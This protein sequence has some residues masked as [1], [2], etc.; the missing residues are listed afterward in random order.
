MDQTTRPPLSFGE[1]AQMRVREHER[2]YPVAPNLVAPAGTFAYPSGT[3][4][5]QRGTFA[6]QE[7]GREGPS[8]YG[9][10]LLKEPVWKPVVPLYFWIGGAAGAASTLSAMARLVGGRALDPLARRARLVGAVGDLIG[11][12]LLTYDLGRPA[13]FLNMLRVFNP[14]SPMSIGSWVL[15]SSG[16]ANTGALLL[17]DRRGFLGALG[18]LAGAI[19]G[20]IGMPLAGYTG[21]L[22]ANTAVP[23]WNLGRRSLPLLFMASGVAT[24]GSLLTVTA[25]SDRE[26]AAAER[27]A[28]AGKIGELAAT[29]AL[30]YDVRRESPRAARPL[31]RGTSGALLTTATAL[32]AASLLSSLVPGRSRSKLRNTALLGALGSLLLRFA[33]H[34]AGKSSARDPQASFAS[35]RRIPK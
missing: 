34:H 14:R 24:A 31:T 17:Q 26:R 9:L 4:A 3:S 15:A 11:A 7:A 8:Y 10:P 30:H 22:L 12:G 33:I 18:D 25:T 32:T 23:L 6:Y 19:G 21:V 2:E 1:A 35:Q 13:R 29:A 27:Y 16:A 28:I 20:L 5:Y